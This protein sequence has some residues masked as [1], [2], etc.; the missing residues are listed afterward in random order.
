MLSKEFHAERRWM[1][2]AIKSSVYVL[3]L[4]T[5]KLFKILIHFFFALQKYS[6]KTTN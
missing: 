2:I 4:F 3:F 1:I 5:N 6:P